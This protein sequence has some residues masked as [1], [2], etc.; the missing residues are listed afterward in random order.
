MAGPE[1]NRFVGL[2]EAMYRAVPWSSCWRRSCA[3]EMNGDNPSGAVFE[4]FEE[5]VV[6]FNG[7][8]VDEEDGVADFDGGVGGAHDAFVLHRNALEGAVH[9]ADPRAG[10]AGDDVAYGTF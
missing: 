4:D 7:V 3:E 5:V 8:L 10:G 9:N 6:G 1:D 2:F